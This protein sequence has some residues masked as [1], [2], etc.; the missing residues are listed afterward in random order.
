MR[1]LLGIATLLALT[2]HAADSPAEFF[3]MRVRPVLAR[4]CYSCHA[5]S[6]MGGLEL[7][8][9]VGLLQGG[10]SGAAIVVGNPDE[11]L[12]M[13]AVTWE[14]DRL[15][16]P[17]NGAKLA[18]AEISDL[19][20]WIKTGA[21]WPDS[22]T[23]TKSKEYVIRPDQK[24]F[25]AF[26]PVKKSAPPQVKN[27]AWIKTPVDNFILAKLEQNGIT[28]N[29]PASRLTLLRRVSYDLSGLPPTPAETAEFLA[30]K[31]PDAYRTVVDR[32]LAG[33]R[34]GE[35]WGRYWLDVA[36][37]SDDKLN[38]TMEEPAPNAFRYRDWVVDAFNADM[39][40]D[41]FVKAQL[42][43]DHMN[44]PKLLPALGMYGLSPEFQDDRV[45]VTTRGFL[46]LTV[47]CAQCHDHKFDPIPTKDYYSLLGIFNS[48]EYK[49]YPL[50]T[51]DVVDSYE[52]KKKRADDVEKELKDFLQRQGD[53]LAT[54]L[55]S[56]T[57]DYVLAAFGRGPK[58]GLDPTGLDGETLEKWQKYV[59]RKEHEHTYLSKLR[60]AK[61]GDDWQKLA[62]EFEQLALAVNREKKEID[63][64]NNITLGGSSKRGDLSQADLASLERD[65]YFLWRDLFGTGGVMFYGDKKI[66]RFLSGEWK[67]HQD[68]LRTRL[69]LD[70]KAVPEKFPF[71][72]ALADKEKLLKQRIHVRGNASTLGDDA[73]P[74]FLT[75][76]S[77]DGR[78]KPFTKGSGRLELAEAIASP[79]NPLT[80]RVMVNR[81]WQ[82]HFGDG[83]VRTTSN[84]GA[85]GE[86]P[87]HPE[88][89]DYLASKFVE[90]GWSIKAMHREIVLSATY[91]QGTV[92]NSAFAIKDPD[93]RLLWKA[94]R[95]RLDA[96][97]LRDSLLFAAGTLDE[98]GAG[99]A[100]PIDDANHKRTLY[101]YVSRK[102]LDNMLALFDFPNPNQTSEQRVAT[103]VP[104]Q[105]LFLLNSGM[106]MDSA[107]QL[108]KRLEKIPETQRISEAYRLLFGRAPEAEEQKLGQAY[109]A[110][111][112][113]AWPEYLQVLM[114]SNEF[115]YVN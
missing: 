4:N 21:T 63:E 36:R 29:K 111:G 71:L 25:W 57:A 69:D 48:S 6:K 103:N 61:D 70:K 45:D 2:G 102:K 101:G 86:K 82:W 112:A 65:K 14:H 88:L 87:S 55:S 85:L 107:K 28:P 53:E 11:S 106:V 34:Y 109:V 24:S 67:R 42:A 97:A 33:K 73:P 105:R 90:S 96:E 110:H 37:Y 22:P 115:L 75:V 62:Q 104:L 50:A 15:K 79:N 52:A 16:M 77:D 23:A 31:S 38:S 44:D 95:K 114:S 10:K 32:L 83:I 1:R 100:K 3:E 93:N 49:E 26:Q 72:H 9:R 30:D 68:L 99:Q 39:P 74:A 35:R 92:D 76:L 12:L 89:L 80:P 5:Q 113:D 47:A 60:A 64:K 56:R 54:I 98:T 43:A 91:Q 27:S 19:K 66:D 41:K 40:Y 46:G 81:L 108:V 78:P 18:D 8:S 59:K 20:E 51:K 7:T 13:K 58:D 84:F 94:N 17:P